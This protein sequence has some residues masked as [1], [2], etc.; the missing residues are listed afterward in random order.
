MLNLQKLNFLN[1]KKLILSAGCLALI[2]NINSQTLLTENFEG[3]GLPA[4]WSKTQNTPS[5]GWEFGAGLGSQYWAIPN[6]TNYAASNDDAHDN[7]ATTANLA[8][9]DRLISPSLDLTSQTALA[10][11]FD[12]YF[13]GDYNSVATVE[14]S[15]NGGTSWSTLLTLDP[16]ADWQNGLVANLSTYVGQSDV[17]IAFRHNDMGEWASGFAIDNVSIYVPSAN[18]VRLNTITLDRYSAVNVNNTLTMNVTN[19]GSSPITALTIDW[20]DGT[21]HSQVISGLNIAPFAS[22]NVN[23]PTAISYTIAVEK[24][25]NVDITDVNSAIDAN[26]SNNTG[27]KKFNTLSQ[28]PAKKV[29]IEEGTGTWCGWCPRGAVA[30]EAMYNNHPNDFIGIA[31]HNSDP[32]TVT[33][34]DNG[35]NFSGFPGC[36]VDRVLL[37]QGVSENAFET[38]YQ[39]RI[40]VVS[41]ASISILSSGT[42]SSITLDVSAT[43]YTS[44]SSA[45]Y[46]LGVIVIEDNVTGTASGYNQTNYYS[47]GGNGP[48]GG[49]ENLPDPVP[50]ADMVYDHVGRALLGGYS[51]QTNSVPTSLS[52]GQTASYTFNYTVPSTSNI[53]NMKAVAV[54]ID[55]TT[56][57][58]VNA[59]SIGLGSAGIN[60]LDKIEFSV[61]PNPA[62]DI[63]NVSFEASNADYAISLMD[64][65]G[66]VVSSQELSN[67]NGTQ[68]IS[69][70]TE[71][72]A[73][74]SY[75]I[76][77]KSNG[78]TTTTNVVVK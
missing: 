23:H 43:F 6:H 49:Y 14:V 77:I 63:V 9:L 2:L 38:Y 17:R 47:G 54:L 51:G 41:P 67:A 35:A 20:N 58:I 70:S 39:E 21:S 27:T 69:F 10:L 42:G 32:M 36:N 24:T 44:F 60:S 40:S 4:G 57:E 50:A 31:V 65:Q 18:D 52:D 28:V 72:I 74:G 55:Q 12:G 5:I 76:S 46:R 7:S 78:M 64:L 29:I 53:A 73:K 25:I 13:T 22:A 59:N 56:G 71:S 68:L 61:Y 45:N 66:R 26:P 37:D 75:I 1:M 48:M 16:S 34:Y 15:T 8:D 33:A 3:T 30:M 11:S 62:T 19:L